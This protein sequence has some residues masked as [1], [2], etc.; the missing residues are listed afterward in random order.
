MRYKANGLI[1]IR[2]HK[3]VSHDQIPVAA[4]FENADLH[5]VSSGCD[6]TNMQLFFSN[7]LHN[8]TNALGHIT[9]ITNECSSTKWLPA[10]SHNIVQPPNFDQI[11]T[12]ASDLYHLIRDCYC[13]MH[14]QANCSPILSICA[15]GNA[16]SSV[17][18][19]WVRARDG[20]T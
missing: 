14:F 1:W 6:T 2:H 19:F 17:N 7:L 20:V 10:P 16:V 11:Y 5:N 12:L 13:C 4:R 3:E 8:V 15:Y 9:Y 18:H